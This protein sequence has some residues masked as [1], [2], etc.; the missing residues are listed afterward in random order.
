MRAVLFAIAAAH[1]IFV[2]SH[3]RQVIAVITASMTFI[4]K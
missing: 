2:P 4:F 1:V 3:S